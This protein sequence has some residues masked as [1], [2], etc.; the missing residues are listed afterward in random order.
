MG[1]PLVAQ[2]EKNPPAV[3]ETWVRSLGWKN[4]CTIMDTKSNVCGAFPQLSSN[5][6]TQAGCPTTQLNS[7]TT[8]RQSQ[9]H[10]LKAQSYKTEAT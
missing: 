3:R 7:D 4:C 6:Q 8:W 5:S 1:L 10:R 9:I 2:L